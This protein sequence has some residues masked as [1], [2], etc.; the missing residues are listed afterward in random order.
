MKKLALTIAVLAALFTAP[1]AFAYVYIASNA[2]GDQL[3]IDH[4]LFQHGQRSLYAATRSPGN[5]FGPLE[6]ITPADASYAGNAYVDDSGA[7]LVVAR[8]T[9]FHGLAQSPVSATLLARPPGGDFSDTGLVSGDDPPTWVAAG[10]R[11][12]AMFAWQDYGKQGHYRFR[13]AGGELGPDTPV[14]ADNPYAGTVSIGADGSAVYLWREASQTFVAERPPGGD[15]GAPVEVAEVPPR[16][17]DWSVAASHD[18]RLLMVWSDGHAISG[19]ERPPHGSFGAPFKLAVP[20]KYFTIEGVSVADSGAAAITAGY[21]HHYL[22][23]REPGGAFRKAGSFATDTSLMLPIAHMDDAGDVA[24][25]WFDGER[26]V[27]ASYRPA[28]GKVQK[29]RLI[30]R[31]PPLAQPQSDL[32]GL[33]IASGG[34]A[35]VAWE[36]SDGST[37]RT[38]ARDFAAAK[39]YRAQTLGTLPAFVREGPPEACRPPGEDVLLSSS[40]ATVLGP[41]DNPSACLLARGAPVPLVPDSSFGEMLVS[42]GAMSL[43]GPLLAYV[44]HSNGHSESTT[45]VSVIDLRDPDSGVNGGVYPEGFD[46][47][48]DVIA[49]RLKPNGA[50]AWIDCPSGDHC[51]RV[52]GANKHLAV[53]DAHAHA[54]EPRRLDSGRRID[55]ASFR[56]RGSRL[57]WR[58]AGKLRHATLR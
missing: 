33:A 27:F 14:P 17:A 42:P 52:G 31:R 49:T 46:H 8:G 53:L 30:A 21:T 19:V 6:A 57:T 44:T 1:P 55:P 51:S 36:E 43:A 3:V 15:F 28:G 45:A 25:A 2:R 39:T 35:T 22:Y 24:F 23:A 12:D 34:R 16:A 9:V 40:Q 48:T 58:N 20:G 4:P 26:R 54:H 47:T 5:P 13:P 41:L 32:P 29:P 50:V 11:G 37:I 38:R 7:A 18:G 10:P 56:L